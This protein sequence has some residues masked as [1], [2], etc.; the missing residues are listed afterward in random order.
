[1]FHSYRFVAVLNLIKA[2]LSRQAWQSTSL[3]LLEFTS[4]NF[5]SM[6]SSDENK[7][8]T[9]LE[10]ITRN[11]TTISPCIYGMSIH[12]VALVNKVIGNLITFLHKL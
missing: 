9:Y 7:L 4:L 11:Y 5:T 12:S 6:M 10:T 1:L 2:K 3:V 8:V